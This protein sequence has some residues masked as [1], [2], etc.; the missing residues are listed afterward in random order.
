MPANQLNQFLHSRAGLATGYII[1]LALLAYAA[2]DL[3]NRYQ[4]TRE[5]KAAISTA[6]QAAHEKKPARQTIKNT[7]QVASL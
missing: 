2:L 1:A 7:R 6:N 3:Y 5:M 4:N